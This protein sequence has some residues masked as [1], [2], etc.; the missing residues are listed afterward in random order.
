MVIPRWPDPMTMK[1]LRRRANVYILIEMRP[2]AD[3]P[4]TWHNRTV[5]VGGLLLILATL[6]HPSQETVQAIIEFEAR[7]VASH[8][9]STAAYVLILIG[10]PCWY[11]AHS[12]DLG[13]TGFFGFVVTFVGTS[14]L[15][16]SG[17]FGF[18]APV[19][20]AQAP[21]AI[22]GIVSYTPVVVL[23]GLAAIGFMVGFLIFG[24]AIARSTS[25]PRWTGVLIAVGAPIHLVAAA[26]AL[27]AVESVWTLAVVG[28]VCLGAGLFGVSRGS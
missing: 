22:D 23:N 19:L 10:L 8:A 26:F 27:L 21:S 25:L 17:N 4:V 18:L 16:I 6:L 3:V 5:A 12:E 7:L 20:A 24:I 9:V 2:V 11:I 14:L 13:R 28:S 1:R 15:A